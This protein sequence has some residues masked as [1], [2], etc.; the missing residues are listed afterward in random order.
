[1]KRFEGFRK[2]S[3]EKHQE[4]EPG[5]ALPNAYRSIAE[6]LEKNIPFER[7]AKSCLALNY[8]IENGQTVLPQHS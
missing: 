8:M 2:L 4:I 6:H 3:K 5:L 1:M 7:N